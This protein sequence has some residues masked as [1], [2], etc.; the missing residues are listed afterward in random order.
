MRGG[1]GTG[2]VTVI[3]M[4]ACGGGRL[5]GG[6]FGGSDSWGVAWV[7]RKEEPWEGGR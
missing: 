4:L 6:T 2:A 5:D 3:L 7:G 1:D